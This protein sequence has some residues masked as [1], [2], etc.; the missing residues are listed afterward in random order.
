NPARRRARLWPRLE[1]PGCGRA[2][3][4]KKTYERLAAIVDSSEDAIVGKDLNGIVT[5]WNVGAKRIF[6]YSAS[7]MVGAS[8]RELVPAERQSEEDQIFARIRRGERV[9]HMDTVRV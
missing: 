5:S 7:E 8:I 4:A 2:Q 1:F 6:G 9:N 3:Q